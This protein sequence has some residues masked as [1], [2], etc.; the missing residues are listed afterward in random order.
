MKKTLVAFIAC[1]EC[2]TLVP[3]QDLVAQ[4]WCGMC[5]RLDHCDKC[6]EVHI[7]PE[8]GCKYKQATAGIGL[9]A[10]QNTVKYVGE[11]I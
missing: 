9:A 10:L 1:K 2:G 6:K 4:M 7:A 5:G 3:L 8:I 11:S